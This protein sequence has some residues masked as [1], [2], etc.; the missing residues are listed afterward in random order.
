MKRLLILSSRVS[1]SLRGGMKDTPPLDHPSWAVL[2][3]DPVGTIRRTVEAISLLSLYLLS[4]CPRSKY[5]ISGG[6]RKL[7]VTPAWCQV[8]L[9]FCV[10]YTPSLH[11]LAGAITV[12]LCFSVFMSLSRFSKCPTPPSPQDLYRGDSSAH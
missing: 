4:S 10:D 1:F 8:S 3:R 11:L 7:I 2:M 12:Y 5:L 6:R 9:S